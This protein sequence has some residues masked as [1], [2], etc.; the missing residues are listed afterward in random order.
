ML[1]AHANKQAWYIRSNLFQNRFL[2]VG[3]RHAAASAFISVCRLIQILVGAANIDLKT[4]LA[5]TGCLR[6]E[7]DNMGVV[8]R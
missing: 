7:K 2:L 1:A 4:R 8:T 5:G 3:R 6:D